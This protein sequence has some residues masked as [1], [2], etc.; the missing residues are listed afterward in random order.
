MSD[1]YEELYGERYGVVHRNGSVTIALPN[2]SPSAVHARYR[3]PL[4]RAVRRYWFGALALA[5]IA[6][7]SALGRGGHIGGRGAEPH[8]W[9][10]PTVTVTGG[11]LALLIAWRSKLTVNDRRVYF[12]AWSACGALAALLAPRVIASETFV[13]VT[14][15]AGAAIFVAFL[16]TVGVLVRRR[17]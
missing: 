9:L 8:A 13:S 14:T 12:S 4:W 11:L 7:W 17:R 5:G 3:V 1:D 6:W 16:I 2:R 15:V 10:I